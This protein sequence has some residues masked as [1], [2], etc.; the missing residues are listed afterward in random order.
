MFRHWLGCLIV[1]SSIVAA[2]CQR[3]ASNVTALGMQDAWV[4][5]PLPGRTMTAGYVSIANATQNER[6][7]TGVSSAQF[8]RVEL[9]ETTMVD[10]TMQMRQLTQLTIPAGATAALAPGGMH[11]MLI[12]ARSALEDGDSVTVT[13]TVSDGSQIDLMMPVSKDNPYER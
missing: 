13:F 7:I 9:H 6:V 8:A 4:R 3:D 12:D 11:L 2:G 5:A 1:V 10:N